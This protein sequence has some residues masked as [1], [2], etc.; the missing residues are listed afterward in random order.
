MRAY[1]HGLDSFT[2]VGRTQTLNSVGFAT[3]RAFVLVYPKLQVYCGTT[4]TTGSITGIVGNGLGFSIDTVTTT[5]DTITLNPVLT[6][7]TTEG[8]I[9]ILNIA[10]SPCAWTPDPIVT[11]TVADVTY[12][13]GTGAMAVPVSSLFST[14]VCINPLF[15]Y[16]SVTL[17]DSSPLPSFMTLNA[18][19]SQITVSTSSSSNINTYSI[20]VQTTLLGDG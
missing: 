19:K 13:I 6:D 12:Y 2:V 17:A 3:E 10:A 11:N 20:L 14:G 7:D 4:E 18:L 9:N 5:P 8:I 1:Q 15:T 16:T